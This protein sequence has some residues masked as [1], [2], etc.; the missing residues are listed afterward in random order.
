MEE[1]KDLVG[2]AKFVAEAAAELRVNM[3]ESK[4]LTAALEK[5]TARCNQRLDELKQIWENNQAV[6]E[7]IER[8]RNL[9]FK[10]WKKI[11]IVA[12]V[13]ATIGFVL[14]FLAA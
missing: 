9:A 14:G 7:R 4:Q 10:V 8:K 12:G 1:F 5:A 13:S 2:L 3:D 11:G 6:E